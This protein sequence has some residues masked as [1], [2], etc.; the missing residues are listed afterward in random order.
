M[1]FLFLFPFC[2][3][4]NLV[5]EGRVKEDGGRWEQKKTG[6]FIRNKKKKENSRFCTTT[7]NLTNSRTGKMFCFFLPRYRKKIQR[8]AAV[9]PLF[10]ALHPLCST[11]PPWGG[12]HRHGGRC[13]VLIVS[14]FDFIFC[15]CWS[16]SNG[17]SAPS[18]AQSRTTLSPPCPAPLWALLKALGSAPLQPPSVPGGCDRCS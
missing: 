16:S 18:P 14:W 15:C 17:S 7:N 4:E 6:E 3:I 1:Y 5:G 13:F 8:F 11:V 9:C 2:N 12:M 10:R